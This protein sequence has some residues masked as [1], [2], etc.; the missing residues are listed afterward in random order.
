MNAKIN[1][2]RLIFLM[3][4]YNI[5]VKVNKNIREKKNLYSIITAY[6][7]NIKIKY[8]PVVTYFFT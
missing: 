5:G 8:I 3:N 7:L 6:F 1:H 2:N 4:Y